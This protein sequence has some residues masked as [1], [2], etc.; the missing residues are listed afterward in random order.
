[1]STA[2]RFSG[3]YFCLVDCSYLRQEAQRDLSQKWPHADLSSAP[4]SSARHEQS[5]SGY[6]WVGSHSYYYTSFY[7]CSILFPV[8][9]FH[10]IVR[11]S[12]LSLGRGLIAPNSITYT[13]RW[14]RVFGADLSVHL[15]SGAHT[16]SRLSPSLPCQVAHVFVGW[17]MNVSVPDSSYYRYTCVHLSTCNPSLECLSLVHESAETGRKPR[18]VVRLRPFEERTDSVSLSLT[19]VMAALQCSAVSCVSLAADTVQSSSVQR[20]CLL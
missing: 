17:R 12:T 19:V 9:P 10:M 16:I 5:S 18:R 14:L 6:D 13:L 4:Q 1:M 11:M 3:I 2:P 8:V 15:L 20:D 7:E